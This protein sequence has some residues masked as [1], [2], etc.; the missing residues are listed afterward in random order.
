MKVSE[1]IT[2]IALFV[3]FSSIPLSPHTGEAS[4]KVDKEV[5]NGKVVRLSLEEGKL[6]ILKKNL[7]IAIQK[8][9]PQ[10]ETIRINR[11]KGSFD[12]VISGSFIR[13]DSTTP[14]GTRSSV[15]AGGRTDVESETYILSTGISGKSMIGT[16]YSIEFEDIW[17]KNTFN[18]FQAEYDAF[19]GIRIR[20]PL[21]KD[22]GYD[23]NHVQIYIAQKNRDISVNELKKRIID[24]VAEFK[25]AYWDLV[26]SLEDLK[27]KHESLKLAESLLDLN[28]KRLR[29]EVISPLEVTQ[30]EAGMAARKEDV[31]IAEK[32]VKER[33]NAL[34][35]LI[36]RDI[37]ALKDTKILPTDTPTI[38]PVMPDLEESYR[39]G[40]ENRPDYQKTKT[41]LKKNDITIQYAKN[42]RFPRI[43][44]EAS[45]GF[46]G[47][48]TSF[49]DSLDDIEGNPEWT[50]G[51]AVSFPLGNRTARGDLKIAQLEAEQSLLN[52]K[53]LE[54]E[55]LIEID[56]AIRDLET[57]KQRI[58]VTKISKR[59]AEESLQAEERKFK[60]GL[61]TSHNVLEFQEDL[62][63]AKSR[64]ISAIIDYNKSLVELS[65]IKGTLLEEEGIK[66]A[67]Y[68]TK[69]VRR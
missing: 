52:L 42:Q 35:R 41:E 58:E 40:L 39:T 15:A 47:L 57:N 61:S 38:T 53:K 48:G 25:N 66:L 62:V 68:S 34:K 28:R 18:T 54:Q 43:D 13:E 6:L 69:L 56:N 5:S 30:A 22:L 21:L 50:L 19:V 26:L 65:H 11:E 17:T 64:E 51:I 8:I 63:E 45:Y 14:L 12:P 31:L 10:V 2:V 46:N 9:T 59:L 1:Y 29:A 32:L 20:Q 67:E 3:F 27:V 16:E 44:L 60:E 7:D 49:G 55:I 36:S 24:T 4:E 33:G 23:I 37:Y